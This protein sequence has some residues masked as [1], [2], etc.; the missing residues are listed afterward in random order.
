[1]DLDGAVY[2]AMPLPWEGR[3]DNDS[4]MQLTRKIKCAA[5]SNKSNL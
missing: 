5:D 2:A 4:M 3:D 1:M